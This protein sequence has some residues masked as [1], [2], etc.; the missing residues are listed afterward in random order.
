VGYRHREC[1]QW[2]EPYRIAQLL[3]VGLGWKSVVFGKALLAS[4]SNILLL[5]MTI[6]GKRAA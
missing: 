6:T 1:R 5:T 3:I 4:Y 2:K